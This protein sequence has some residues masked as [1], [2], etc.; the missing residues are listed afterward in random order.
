[1]II[2]SLCLSCC[3]GYSV[4]L[5]KYVKKKKSVN[6]DVRAIHR[7]VVSKVSKLSLITNE[8]LKL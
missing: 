5:I 6:N 8:K 3:V 2:D 7:N 4:K 1:M